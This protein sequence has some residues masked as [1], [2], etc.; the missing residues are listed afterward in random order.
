MEKAQDKLNIYNN[1]HAEVNLLA[2][3]TTYV[4]KTGVAVSVDWVVG[5]SMAV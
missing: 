1:R 2:K 4:P 3:T 5:G